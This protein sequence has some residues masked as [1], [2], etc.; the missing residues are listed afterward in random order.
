MI[1]GKGKKQKIIDC[2]K[3]EYL[4]KYK[5]IVGII[6][7]YKQYKK[8]HNYKCEHDKKFE[9]KIRSYWKKY[10]RRVSINE[11]NFYI[12]NSSIKSEK[13]ITKK[14]Y[15]KEIEL[16]LNNVDS[17]E[18][19]SNKNYLGLFLKNANVP[20]SIIRK[21]NGTLMDSNYNIITNKQSL[22]II[23]NYADELIYKPAIN[24]C[25]GKGIIFLNKDFKDC[26]IT[27]IVNSKSDFVIQKVIEQNMLF[28]NFNESSVNTVRVLSLLFKND[29]HI[30]YMILRVGKKGMRVDNSSSGGYQV[31]IKNSGNFSDYIVDV[32]NNRIEDPNIIKRFKGKK[33]PFYDKICLEVKNLHPY[34]AECKLVG[35]DITID[36]F[37]NPII[38]E[39][40][41]DDIGMTD[42]SQC[43][44]GPLFGKM[45]DEVLK[46]V[47]NK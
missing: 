7:S 32:D 33:M 1:E 22:E 8:F 10:K 47:F 37:G 20:V 34:L 41:L 19:I 44:N 39:I 30:L 5:I 25:G 45:T 15:H 27:D 6:Y 38:I 13:F 23:R 31:V 40:N 17:A 42:K 35:W 46:Y 18:I 12:N 9:K 26:E 2:I 36:K 29:V 43:V 4:R 14:I 11:I 3:K 28:S 24:S 16:K 21:I